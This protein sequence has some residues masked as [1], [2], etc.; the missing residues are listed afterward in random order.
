MYM[1]KKEALQFASKNE[2][3]VFQTDNVIWCY[4]EGQESQ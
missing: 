1:Y 4:Q 3:E 2:Q